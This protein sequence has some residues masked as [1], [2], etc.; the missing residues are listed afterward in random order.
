V[1]D[2]LEW[3]VAC[4]EV[5]SNPTNRLKPSHKT[6]Q[7][8]APNL[9]HRLQTVI[10][11]VTQPPKP[12]VSVNLAP[13]VMIGAPHSFSGF[14]IAPT[15]RVSLYPSTFLET[16]CHSRRNTNFNHDRKCGNPVGIG[17]GSATVSGYRLPRRRQRPRDAT[18]DPLWEGGSEVGNPESGYRAG[19]ARHS[20]SKPFT[21]ASSRPLR[22][23]SEGRDPSVPPVCGVGTFGEKQ[24]LL[25]RRGLGRRGGPIHLA[26]PQVSWTPCLRPERRGLQ[27]NEIP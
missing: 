26:A 10:G 15:T 11:T 20:G 23:I 12:S 9:S 22:R 3:G 25:P 8:A 21:K 16:F 5:A 7:P 18:G 19:R 1:E 2:L 13:I 27:S 6:R 4:L 24:R 17:D 14:P